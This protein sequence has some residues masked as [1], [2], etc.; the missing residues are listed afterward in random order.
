MVWLGEAPNQSKLAI[1]LV[2][3]DFDFCIDHKI[4]RKTPLQFFVVEHPPGF[5]FVFHEIMPFFNAGF[6][7]FIFNDFPASH[8]V[9]KII[10]KNGVSVLDVCNRKIKNHE[11]RV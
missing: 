3:E 5:G 7:I 2:I 1:T 8:I 9:G 10:F 11:K 4:F 6:F